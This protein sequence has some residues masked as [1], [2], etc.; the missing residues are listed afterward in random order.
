M[1]MMKTRETD[2]RSRQQPKTAFR[3]GAAALWLAIIIV[4]IINRDKIT[5][6]GILDRTPANTALAIL[7]FLA[8][9]ALKSVTVVI[10]C[11]ILYAVGGI[12]FPPYIAIPVNLLGAVI[13]ITIPFF[14][15]RKL[16]GNEVAG[17]LEKYPK[18]QQMH[19]FRR[20]NDLFF[21]FLVRIISVFPS[22]A[23]SLYMG[24]SDADYKKY[25]PG[26]LLG[27]LPGII[28]ITV[29]GMSVNDVGSPAF[30]ISAAAEILIAVSSAVG[31][32]LYQKKKRQ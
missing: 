19:E 15:G 14:I 9:Y 5:V 1:K 29:M 18:L 6:E 21:S 13:M 24:A 32:A 20:E 8:M 30:L 17:L 10:F 4:C 22:D 2:A 27:M 3:I 12:L 23:V 26:S 28:A 7:V 11:G 25:L 16:G 31:F